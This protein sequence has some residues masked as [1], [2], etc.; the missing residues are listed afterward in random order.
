MVNRT[1]CSKVSV[2]PV[3][4]EKKAAKYVH[5]HLVLFVGVSKEVS[6]EVQMGTLPDQDQVCGAISEVGGGRQAFGTPGTRTAHTGR[7]NGDELP[8][9]HVPATAAI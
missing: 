8:T 9:D 4:F 6:E 2:F 5:P 1:F 3:V 7:V